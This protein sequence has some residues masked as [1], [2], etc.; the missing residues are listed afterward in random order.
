MTRCHSH[1]SSSRDRHLD[2]VADDEPRQQLV[3]GE[4]AVLRIV[5]GGDRRRPVGPR[6]RNQVGRQRARH[7][8]SRDVLEGNVALD[9]VRARPAGG[10][11]L[12]RAGVTRHDRVG[13][14]GVRR[15]LDADELRVE[16]G[17]AHLLRRVQAEPP[18]EDGR[19]ELARAG[20]QRGHQGADR[21]G[22]PLLLR[23]LVAEGFH[24]TEGA[25]EGREA[26]GLGEVV[27]LD[28][29]F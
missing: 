20:G 5:E 13:L 9:D 4:V 14:P 7:H 12:P 28:G 1:R 19:D 11:D 6:R 2:R 3:T 16:V 27:E 17:V 8:L 26:G 25:G 22:R 21:D 10:Q 23:H 15:R 24:G 29:H 18:G